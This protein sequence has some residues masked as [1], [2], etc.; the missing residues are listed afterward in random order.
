LAYWACGM[1]LYDAIG[2]AFGTISTGG[3]APHNASIAYYHSDILYVVS[4]I[5]MMLGGTNFSLHFLAF[6]KG[7]WRAYFMDQEFRGYIM[8]F[9]V[10]SV[11]VSCVLWVTGTYNNLGQ[12]FINGFYQ[13]IS[14][15]TT[16]GFVT[17]GNYPLWPLFVPFLLLFI[18][19]LGACSGSTTGGIKIIRGLLLKRQI[20]REIKRLIHPQGTFPVKL[21]TQAVPERV[22]NGVWAFIS[23]Y[24][25]IFLVLWMALMATNLDPVTSFSALATCIANVGPGLGKVAANFSTIS[26]TARWILVFAMLIGRLEVFT[27]LVLIS[28][29]FWKR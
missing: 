25:M 1:S 12:A 19:L 16:T 5:F 21:G 2:Y 15:G 26:T 7:N 8:V 9:F 10:V 24:L 20:T 18:G 13:V 28:P 29:Q 27:V 4:M 3:Y 11:I 17:D 23:A 6:R 22:M 14:F